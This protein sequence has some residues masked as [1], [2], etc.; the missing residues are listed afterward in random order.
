MRRIA[1]AAWA[2][3]PVA[4]AAFRRAGEAIGAA[5]A[6][7]VTLLDLD[8]VVVGGLLASAGSVLF[9]PIADGYRRHA[10][11]D[12]ASLPRVVPAVLGAD[13]ALL[14]AAAA[15]LRPGEYW[16]YSD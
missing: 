10:A 14:G 9:N 2:G 16:P 5:V 11:L 8:V 3:D 4:V 12:Y 15:V 7:A 13:A 6:D 1:E